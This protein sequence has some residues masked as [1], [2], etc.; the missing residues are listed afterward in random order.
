MYYDADGNPVEGVLSPE[1][2]EEL[3]KQAE[4]LEGKLK[5]AEGLEAQLKEKE[6][7]LN[8]LSN[9][10]YN[11]KRLREKTEAEVDEMKKKM[12]E[13]E[14]LLLTEVFELTKEREAEKKARFDNA[15]DE[16]LTALSG[17]D[18]ALKKSIEAAEAELAGTAITEKD[19]EDR[20]RKA[21]ILAKG[22]SPKVNSIFSGYSSSY[23]EPDTKPKKFSDTEQGKASLKEWFPELAD[24]VIKE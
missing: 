1:E 23:R 7:E 22:E 10:D 9:K 16:V 3:K 12:S 11:F 19:V 15:R 6:E 2:A 8:K 17:G 21:Y 18:E 20:L 13:K 4:E 24:K 5:T 14:R